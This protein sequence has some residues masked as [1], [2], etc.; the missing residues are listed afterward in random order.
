MSFLTSGGYTVVLSSHVAANS[1]CDDMYPQ[2]TIKKEVLDFDLT[3]FGLNLTVYSRIGVHQKTGALTHLAL[4]KCSTFI[5]CLV[6]RDQVTV[7]D[8]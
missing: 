2:C 3:N 6:F 4:L 8:F 1:Y 5:Y 7:L